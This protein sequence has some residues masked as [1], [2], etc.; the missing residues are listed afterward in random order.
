VQTGA[1]ADEIEI[2]D[3]DPRWPRLFQT[4][5]ARL[6]ALLPAGLIMRIEH[7]GSTAV[8]GLAAKPV[9]DLMALVASLAE[10]RAV[11]VEPLEADGYAYWADNPNP[12]RMLFVRG[13]PPS[14]PRRTHHLHLTESPAILARHLAFRDALRADREQADRYGRLKLDLAVAHAQDREAYTR[15]KA[16]HIEAVL[17]AVG[18]P[19]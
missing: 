10:A 9:I 8:P 15:A 18:A 6:T 4:E 2:A 16:A 12:E 1:V 14:A 11:A 19:R 17:A 13:L 3:Y 7:I 5:A